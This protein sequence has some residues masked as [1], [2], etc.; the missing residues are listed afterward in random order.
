MAAGHRTVRLARVRKAARGDPAIPGPPA[1]SGSAR[2]NGPA[3][4]LPVDPQ[5]GHVLARLGARVLVKWDLKRAMRAMR[6]LSTPR[7]RHH[8]ALAAA[9]VTDTSGV[10]TS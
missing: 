8:L 9:A 4:E 7:G 3:A 1:T 2:R 10:A 6:R 5:A